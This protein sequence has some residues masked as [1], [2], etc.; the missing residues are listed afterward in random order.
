MPS[1]RT[2]DRITLWL[3]PPLAASA[4]IVSHSGEQ[5]LLLAGGFLF[6]GLM[7]GPDLDI[8]SVQYRRWGFLRFIWH[9]YQATLKHRS[10]LSHGPIVGTFVRLLYL[11]GILILA[12][13][14]LLTL[15][16]WDWL[17]FF[18]Q[19][20]QL[21]EIHPQETI[22]LLIGLELGSISHSLSDSL[23]SSYKRLKRHPK[24]RRRR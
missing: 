13:I 3:L 1:G 11:S 16:N 5:T 10:W 23:G 21:I 9:P 2:H 6:S 22:A 18:E 4:F 19:A 20:V 7:F 15:L 24:P 17:F 12:G 8:H 14:P